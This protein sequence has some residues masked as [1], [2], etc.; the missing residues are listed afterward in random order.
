MAESI[1]VSAGGSRG[2]GN[3]ILAKVNGSPVRAGEIKKFPVERGQKVTI[4]RPGS[5]TTV[6][7]TNTTS[8]PVSMNGEQIPAGKSKVVEPRGKIVVVV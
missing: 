6:R 5:A 8:K 4:E 2:S 3:A 7:V 1:T